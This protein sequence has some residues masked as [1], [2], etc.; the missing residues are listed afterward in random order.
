[1][2]LF[3]SVVLFVGIVLFIVGP[4][5]FFATSNL[6]VEYGDTKDV[7]ALLTFSLVVFHCLGLNGRLAWDCWYA[8]VCWLSWVGWL[9]WVCR[10]GWLLNLMTSLIT[11]SWLSSKWH[12]TSW[13]NV[14]YLLAPT[15]L[16]DKFNS[17]HFTIISVNFS[18]RKI[19][20]LLK[21]PDI[22]LNFGGWTTKYSVLTH[23]FESLTKYMT[24]TWYLDFL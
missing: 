2:G 4:I 22:F 3:F 10:L 1:M 21:F 17:S 12:L 15:T 8:W 7:C 13:F 23:K 18:L 19:H 5:A 20:F 24:G 14:T 11:M 9:F 6:V 16:Q